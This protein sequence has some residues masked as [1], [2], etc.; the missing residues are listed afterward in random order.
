MQD[1]KAR[2]TL[3]QV[4]VDGLGASMLVTILL[5]LWRISIGDILGGAGPG[6]GPSSGLPWM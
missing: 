6:S 1:P 4:A 5:D 3:S 2:F